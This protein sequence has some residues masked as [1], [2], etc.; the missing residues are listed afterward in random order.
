VLVLT[1]A[2]LARM[3]E[4]AP[5]NDFDAR[6]FRAN[7]IIDPPAGVAGFV[8]NDWVGRTLCIGDTVRLEITKPCMRCVMVN[9]PT[10]DLP[11]NP[12][13]LKA[14]FEHNQGNVGAKAVVSRPGHVR[15][16]DPVT[17]Q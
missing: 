3:R 1:T 17:L 12:M 16:G 13:T 7:I 9:L 8:E 10:G 2:S 14:T 4:L 11:A 15:V 5:E 6:R